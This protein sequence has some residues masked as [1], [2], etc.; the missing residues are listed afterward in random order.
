MAM[1]NPDD[2]AART[3]RPLKD[4][5]ADKDSK[6]KVYQAGGHPWPRGSRSES[7][8]NRLPRGGL[9][10]NSGPVV[11]RHVAAN[12]STARWPGAPLQ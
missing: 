1:P 7:L 10:S 6:L 3:R 5:Y 11:S 12:H 2:P 4:N 9:A 8:C